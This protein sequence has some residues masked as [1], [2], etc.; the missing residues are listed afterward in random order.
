MSAFASGRL[1]RQWRAL[2][3]L[4]A[5]ACGLGL[6]GQLKLTSRQTHDILRN[7]TNRISSNADCLI[8]NASILDSAVDTT[9]IIM[10][11]RMNFFH[12]P[13][14]Q[15]LTDL[16]CHFAARPRLQAQFVSSTLI[17]A[18]KSGVLSLPSRSLPSFAALDP[19]I[20]WTIRDPP[21]EQSQRRNIFILARS[22]RLEAAASVTCSEPTSGRLF[23]SSRPGSLDMCSPFA[24][25]SALSRPGVRLPQ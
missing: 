9:N 5:S 1:L 14:Q 18:C 17:R 13:F 23:L 25:S 16:F 15:Q 8:Q 19:P 6:V 24:I 12:S 2:F 10:R 21:S 4:R 7:S 22:F 20:R 3:S 11:W